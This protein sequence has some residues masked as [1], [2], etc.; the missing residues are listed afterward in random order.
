MESSGV[1]G[2][3]QISFGVFKALKKIKTAGWQLHDG[4]HARGEGAE[5]TGVLGGKNHPFIEH[6]D[7]VKNHVSDGVQVKQTIPS[8]AYCLVQ[9]EFPNVI[10]KKRNKFISLKMN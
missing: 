9:F 10:E 4:S 7:F 3:T 1:A 5:L 2:I 6:F 8:P